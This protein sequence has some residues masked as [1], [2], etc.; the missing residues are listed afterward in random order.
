MIWLGDRSYYYY[1]WQY[2]IQ[3]FFTYFLRTRIENRI[4]FYGLELIVLV[5]I[6]EISYQFRMSNKKFRSKKLIGSL[7]LI[8]MLN[9]VS[10]AIG[11]KK[12]EEMDKFK[13]NFSQNEAEIK[14]EMKMQKD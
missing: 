6:S 14:R 8:I 5:L 13:Q 12:Q 4:L 3:V 11:N 2:I 1:L 9:I 7:V 10:F